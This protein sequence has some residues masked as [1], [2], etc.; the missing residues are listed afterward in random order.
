MRDSCDGF[1]IKLNVTKCQA[2]MAQSSGKNIKVKNKYIYIFIK[3]VTF[4]PTLAI[5]ARRF[6]RAHCTQTPLS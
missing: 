5:G 4:T 6:C 1:M 2:K 3:R